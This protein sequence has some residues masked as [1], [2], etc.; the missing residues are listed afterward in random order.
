MERGPLISILKDMAGTAREL[1]LIVPGEKDHLEIRNV[2][3]VAELHS[4]HGI[5]VRTKQNDIWIDASH[6]SA[7]YQARDDL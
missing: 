1:D 2:V 6:I 7:A 5:H 4:S 3:E